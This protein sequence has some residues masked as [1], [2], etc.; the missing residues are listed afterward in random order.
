MVGPGGWLC[1]GG[2]VCERRSLSSRAQAQVD[3]LFSLSIRRRM[4]SMGQEPSGQVGGCC[5]VCVRAG[6]L[7]MPRSLLEGVL[8]SFPGCA[9]CRLSPV[10]TAAFL[11]QSA[12]SLWWGVI[13][14]HDLAAGFFFL[15]RM[16]RERK[17]GRGR[18]RERGRE[19]ERG[20]G[21]RRRRERERKREGDI[22][23]ER[24]R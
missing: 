4:V 6:A 9:R 24:D 11:A 5:M 22:E 8:V 18:G 14:R 20:R 3:G 10:G 16:P 15:E 17:R 2:V 1:E 7:V 12:G 19:R 21:R 23:R 13:Q